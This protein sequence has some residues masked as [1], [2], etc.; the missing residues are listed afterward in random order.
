MLSVGPYISFGWPK[1][2]FGC[3]RNFKNFKGKFE[4]SVNFPVIITVL[5]ISIG[6]PRDQ[7]IHDILRC[8][9]VQQQN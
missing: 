7:H 6:G 4:N 1:D 9:L 2:V 8:A 5:K 3:P